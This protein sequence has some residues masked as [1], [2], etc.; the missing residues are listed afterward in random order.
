MSSSGQ[1]PRASALDFA[2]ADDHHIR[3]LFIIA[4]PCSLSTIAYHAARTAL[5]FA[6]PVWTTDGEILNNDR[7]CLYGRPAPDIGVKYV[8]LALEPETFRAVIAFLGDVTRR[9]SRVYKDVVQ[10]FAVS[11]WLPGSG[12]RVL[13]LRRRVE[14]VAFAMRQRNWTYPARAA[15]AGFDGRSWTELEV[16]VID[17]LLRA[18]QALEAVPGE[19]VDYDC[20]I[21]D[22]GA[23]RDAL[24]RLYG[25]NRV[26]EIRYIDDGFRRMRHSVLARREEASY[27]SLERL[28]RQR[29]ITLGIPP[30]TGRVPQVEAGLNAG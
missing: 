17:G 16:A 6:E 8:R 27:A 21:E 18:E 20:L 26:R 12:L 9:E 24:V 1:L 28:V 22:E 13:R 25:G 30:H 4:L 29:R 15:S 23:L 14:D 3:S 10:P 7:F 11:A 5:G 19:V 2:V